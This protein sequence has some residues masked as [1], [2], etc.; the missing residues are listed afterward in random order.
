MGQR[1]RK[2]VNGAEGQVGGQWGRGVRVPR[3]PCLGIW[4][5]YMSISTHKAHVWPSGGVRECPLYPIHGIYEC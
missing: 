1:G 4:D 3:T 5:R 2:G